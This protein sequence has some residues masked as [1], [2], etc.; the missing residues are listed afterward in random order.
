MIFRTN[1]RT[2]ERQAAHITIKFTP[3]ERLRDL[4]TSAG[5]AVDAS[6]WHA[7]P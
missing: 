2:G 3:L 4:L 6:L 1:R 5:L 7:S